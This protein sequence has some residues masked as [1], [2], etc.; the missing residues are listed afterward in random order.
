VLTPNDF[1]ALAGVR[2]RLLRFQE[3]YEQVAQPFRWKFTRRDLN[4]LLAKLAPIKVRL[5]EVA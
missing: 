3:Y 2:D 4:T 5:R 1:P